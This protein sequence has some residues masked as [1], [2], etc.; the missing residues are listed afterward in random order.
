M[1][2]NSSLQTIDKTVLSEVT[3]FPLHEKS[4]IENYFIKEINQRKLRSQ[5]LNKYVTI[6]YYID[7]F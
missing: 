4:K 1:N 5:K 3:K 2:K 6:F 7:K